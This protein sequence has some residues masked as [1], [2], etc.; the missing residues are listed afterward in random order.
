MAAKKK[1]A[2]KPVV[3]TVVCQEWL[4]SERGWGCRP[5]GASLHLTN[6][7]L[8]AYVKEY[9]EREK[10]FNPSGAVPDEYSRPDGSP[11]LIEVDAKTYNAVKKSKNGVRL[12]QHEYREIRK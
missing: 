8:D 10:Q 9:W 3:R 5:D 12:W 11:R 1:A 4:E 6:A 7:D 2:R